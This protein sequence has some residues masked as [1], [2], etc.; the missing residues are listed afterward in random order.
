M[1]TRKSAIM[2]ISNK[3]KP[4]NVH[5]EKVEISDEPFVC[6]FCDKSFTT[7]FDF[8][9][10]TGHHHLAYQ[11]HEEFLRFLTPIEISNRV[12]NPM[13]QK[14]WKCEKMT[15][16]SSS[17]NNFQCKFCDEIFISKTVLSSHMRR[18]YGYICRS[19]PK[20][21]SYQESKQLRIRVKPPYKC[22]VCGKSYVFIASFNRHIKTHSKATGQA[23]QDS[24]QVHKPVELINLTDETENLL[25]YGGSSSIEHASSTKWIQAIFQGIKR[26]GPKANC[27]DEL[28]PHCAI[29]LEN[30]QFFNMEAFSCH[31][32]S[33]HCM[34]LEEYGRVWPFKLADNP[35]I[36]VIYVL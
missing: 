28:R 30:P 32:E 10:H 11:S 14:T 1:N 3:D 16:S 20:I 6:R 18:H 22:E 13:D 25:Y 23:D 35:E 8:V 33:E 24:A 26:Q 34:N 19:S 7:K 27:F 29:C 31:V 36:E 15:V 17:E 12:R 9:Y 5:E 2:D 21:L 4:T